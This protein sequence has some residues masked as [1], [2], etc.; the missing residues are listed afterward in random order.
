M[1]GLTRDSKDD[2]IG[3]FAVDKRYDGDDYNEDNGPIYTKEGLKSKVRRSPLK[4]ITYQYEYRS[5]DNCY[6]ILCWYGTGSDDGIDYVHWSKYRYDNDEPVEE[7]NVTP[8]TIFNETLLMENWEDDGDEQ[9]IS[10]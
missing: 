3:F 8:S 6:Y 7:D 5:A 10:R 1:N 2:T 4:I 9:V